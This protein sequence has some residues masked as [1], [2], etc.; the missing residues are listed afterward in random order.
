MNVMNL[1]G[2]GENTD[3]ACDT[4]G[5]QAPLD[6]PRH[7]QTMSRNELT[8]PT[9]QWSFKGITGRKRR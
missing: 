9:G 2:M 7:A 5:F 1:I 6:E 3:R 4:F 8:E